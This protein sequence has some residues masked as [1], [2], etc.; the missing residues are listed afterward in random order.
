MDPKVKIAESE[1]EL[2]KITG[3]ILAIEGTFESKV[4]QFERELVENRKKTKTLSQHIAE[5]SK[6]NSTLRVRSKEELKA[7][8]ERLTKEVEAKNK[9]AETGRM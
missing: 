2:E 5:I 1:A 9:E 3:E 6:E 4:D 7:E 8:K